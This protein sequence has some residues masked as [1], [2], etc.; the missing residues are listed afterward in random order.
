MEPLSI[1]EVHLFDEA[2]ETS[3]EKR[4]EEIE[5]DLKGN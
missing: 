2:A 4:S 1:E 3:E 5:P